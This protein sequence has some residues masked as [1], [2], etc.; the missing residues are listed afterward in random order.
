MTVRTD[1]RYNVRDYGAA[2]DGATLDTSALQRTIDACAAAG[3]GQVAV[4]AGTYLTGTLHLKSHVELHL[5]A[6]SRLLGSNRRE[7]YN[8]D[9]LYPENFASERDNTTGAHL[10]MA[11]R[12]RNISI[13]GSGTID[14][15][16]PAF[17]G[18]I[19]AGKVATPYF[20]T[21]DYS[22]LTWRTS[23]MV[24]LCRCEHV[25]MS[26]VSLVNSPYWTLFLLGC[27]DVQLRGM[28]IL[29]PPATRN[30]DGI[31]IDCS[32]R[33]T[34]SDCLIRTGDDC[35]TL[36]AHERLLGDE[37]IPCE[38]VAVSNCVLSSPCSAIR[39]GVGNGQIRDCSFSNII[40]HETRTAISFNA[41]YSPVSHGATIERLHFTDFTV[42][43]LNP[44]VLHPG[45]GGARPAAIRDISF[46]RFR[47]T[48]FAGSQLAGTELVPLERIRMSEID[49][50]VRG[51]TDNTAFVERIPEDL[52]ISG[53][54]GKLGN[55]A[56]P[57]VLYVVHVEDCELRDFRIRW[58]EPSQVWRDGL[59]IERSSEV[60]IAGLRARQPQQQGGAAVHCRE[61]DGLYITGCRAEKGTD[62]FLQI[63]QSPADA[64]VFCAGNAWGRARTP[65][66]SDVSPS[67]GQ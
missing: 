33:V 3:G 62:T 22:T 2:G 63:E 29:N 11:Y 39:V 25:I 64:V 35:I 55:P 59:R 58:E 37:A 43:A 52:S 61:V 19:P 36:R 31:D 32:R 41:S 45:P 56:L 20:K 5:E 50:V 4:P 18:E 46:A 27:E 10:I 48:A 67:G 9:D 54:Q 40:V 13:T 30:G 57:C 16:S 28:T 24:W 1:T 66:Q 26:D 17:F 47:V 38:Q 8:A 65:V 7:D 51:G 15:N 60:A 12:Q 53:Y 42:D 23:Q 49:W 44:L 6:G 21:G 14:G 34:V